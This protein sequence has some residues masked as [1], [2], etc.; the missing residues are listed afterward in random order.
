MSIITMYASVESGYVQEPGRVSKRLAF[1]KTRVVRKSKGQR[2]R[3]V[4]R[5]PLVW[6]RAPGMKKEWQEGN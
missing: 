6:S 5:L 3:T 1:V 4:E 2:L